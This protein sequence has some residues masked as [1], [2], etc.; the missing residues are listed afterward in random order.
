M[1]ILDVELIDS[2]SCQF[3]GKVFRSIK[4]FYVIQSIQP[5]CSYKCKFNVVYRILKEYPNTWLKTLYIE[6]YPNNQPPQT[7]KEGLF[8]VTKLYVGAL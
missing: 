7:R 5:V 8:E 2:Y 6:F 4:E 3:C 1:K